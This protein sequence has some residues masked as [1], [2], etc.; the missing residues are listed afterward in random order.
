MGEFRFYD[1]PQKSADVTPKGNEVPKTTEPKNNKNMSVPPEL[2]DT[3]LQTGVTVGGTIASQRQK[4][5]KSAARQERIAACGRKPLFGARKKAEYNK[6]VANLGGAQ[7]R[8]ADIPP[9]PFDENSGGGDEGG[10]NKTMLYVGIG[11][12]VLGV[13]GFIL[14]KKFG[15]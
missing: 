8:S 3:L 12:V 13:V 6:C 9:P 14:Y 4:T 15:K 1:T 10:S 7:Q 2:F 5:G 11:V